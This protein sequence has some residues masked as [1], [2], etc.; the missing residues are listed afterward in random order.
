M[1]PPN[2]Q[3]IA[4]MLGGV[5]TL[6]S[7]VLVG[8]AL[9]YGAANSIFNVEGGHIAVVFNRLVGIKD[10]VSQGLHVQCVC[11]HTH[12]PATLHTWRLVPTRSL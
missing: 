3:Q 12:T 5:K 9:V 2:S 6:T 7:V 1:N 11:N 10:T 4:A 8:G